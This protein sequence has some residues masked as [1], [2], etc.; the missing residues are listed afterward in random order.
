MRKVQTL[1]TSLESLSFSFSTFILQPSRN[2]LAECWDCL[3]SLLT[4]FCIYSL[5]SSFLALFVFVE[6]S[7]VLQLGKRH[8]D[9][10]VQIAKVLIAPGKQGHNHLSSKQ[11]N[12][13]DNISI[14]CSVILRFNSMFFI[15]SQNTRKGNGD[16]MTEE[17]VKQSNKQK[18]EKKNW[19]RQKGRNKG[20]EKKWLCT[21]TP[22]SKTSFTANNLQR[23]LKSCYTLRFF[24]PLTFEQ[25]I[26]A[27]SSV[28]SWW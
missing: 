22:Y 8:V 13:N 15:M 4:Q 2:T 5:N 6:A 9:C 28:C 16:S 18:T 25:Y 3:S 17:R 24:F 26:F 14:S 11:S 1:E 12:T 7:F 20:I 10:T 19:V 21:K 27:H 23:L